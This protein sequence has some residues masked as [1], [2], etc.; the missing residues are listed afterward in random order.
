VTRVAHD[1][2]H[3]AQIGRVMARQYAGAVGLW[4][5]YLSILRPA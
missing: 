2:G 3:T 1:L 4:S 5:A